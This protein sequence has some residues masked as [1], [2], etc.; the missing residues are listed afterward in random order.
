[1]KASEVARIIKPYVIGWINNATD[2]ATLN[3]PTGGPGGTTGGTYAPTPHGLDSSH[4][5]SLLPHSTTWMSGLANDTHTIYAHA[6]GSGTR[7]AYQAERLNKSVLAGSGLST[8]GLLTSNVTL[9]LG[10][11][12]TLT[13]TTTNSV[14]ASTHA[15][16]ITASASPGVAESL[17]KT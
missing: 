7:T 17:L 12:T 11:P 9:H 13:S 8:G 5:D 10:T 14:S 1:M 2:L 15:H 6:D 16:A 4:H 3:I